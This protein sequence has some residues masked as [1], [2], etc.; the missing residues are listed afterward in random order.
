MM[1]MLLTTMS[2]HR[3]VQM[4]RKVCFALQEIFR[5]FWMIMMVMMAILTVTVMI[6]FTAEH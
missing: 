5:E 1:I 3:R 2:D 4:V 6:V